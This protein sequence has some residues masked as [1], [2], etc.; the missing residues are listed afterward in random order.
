L[1]T[2]SSPIRVTA[3]K[4]NFHSTRVIVERSVFV[5]KADVMEGRVHLDLKPKLQQP[6]ERQPKQPQNKQPYQAETEE[7]ASTLI[8]ESGGID[9]IDDENR[10]TKATGA[11]PQ[12]SAPQTLF[13]AATQCI[14]KGDNACVIETLRD[15]ASTEAELGLLIETYRS[16]GDT[17]NAEKC[18]KRFLEKY[19]NSNRAEIYRKIVEATP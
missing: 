17:L 8:S 10:P 6:N 11:N 15:K 5:R 7:E 13:Q 1:G 12:E 3:V 16:V 9:S 19:P 4:T 14:A 18:I 2:V